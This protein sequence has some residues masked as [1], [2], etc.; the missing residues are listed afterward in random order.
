MKFIAAALA[1][2]TSCSI[3]QTT[4]VDFQDGAALLTEEELKAAVTGKVLTATDAKGTRW[5]LQF[6]ANGYF[7]INVGN[8]SDSGKWSV[9]DTT[10]C[11]VP[12]RIRA[13]CNHYRSKDGRLLMKRESGEIIQFDPT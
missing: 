12:S 9:K 5:R 10:I 3:A 11:T 6:N 7:F 4:V 1:L 2:A 13:Y 8:F